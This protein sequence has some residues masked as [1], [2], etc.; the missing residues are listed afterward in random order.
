MADGPSSPGTLTVADAEQLVYEEARLIDD[1]RFEEWLERFTA[2]GVYW[3]PIDESQGTSTISTILDDAD[4]RSERVFRLM[5]TP[6]PAQSPP[7]R[8]A[9]LV[10]NVEVDGTDEHG[11]VVV[12]CN[13][14]IAEI[15]PG[16]PLQLG[17]G[18]QQVLVGRCEYRFRHDGAA[19]RIS[20]K[21][22]RLL[23]ADRPIG[24]L[25][26]IV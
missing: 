19:W 17:L 9:H 10:S 13:Q 21:K 12:R 23:N 26:F 22:V 7:S 11:D 3:V 5:H 24:N 8:T 25:T 20:L 4:R 2:D 14:L 6:V 15:R 16:G 1:R 18:R